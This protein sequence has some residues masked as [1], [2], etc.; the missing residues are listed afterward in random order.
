M[1]ALAPAAEVENLLELTVRH[2]FEAQAGQSYRLGVDISVWFEELQRATGLNISVNTGQ[3]AV[4]Q[5]LFWRLCH[6][7]SMPVV[8]VFVFDGPGR[9][10]VKRG[11]NVRGTPHW[12]TAGA[13]SLIKAFGFQY[14]IAP[15]EAEALLAS[16]NMAGI[17]DAVVTTD[18]DAFVFGAA[19]V[20]QTWK[21]NQ[22]RGMVKIFRTANIQEKVDQHLTN[23]GFLLYAL[24][25]GG[26]YDKGLQNCGAGT[27]LGVVKYGLGT[28]LCDA[29]SAPD[30][31][32]ALVTWRAELC[33]ILRTDPQQH[34]GGR[35]PAAADHIGTAF[36]N[37]QTLEAY[38]N[39]MSSLSDTQEPV[40]VAP[41]L[42]RIGELCERYFEWGGR[43]TILD[44]LA[45]HVWPGIVLRMLLTD[46]INSDTT[47]VSNSTSKFAISRII[48]QRLSNGITE[49]KLVFSTDELAEA[50]LSCLHDDSTAR[51]GQKQEHVNHVGNMNVWI[52]DP[53]YKAWVA[54]NVSSH[55]LIADLDEI[56]EEFHKKT[57]NHSPSES[58]DS[59]FSHD[60]TGSPIPFTATA[61][62]VSDP[63]SDDI[64][65]DLTG[66]NEPQQFIMPRAL[67]VSSSIIDLTGPDSPLLVPEEL[68]GSVID[69]T[70]DSCPPSPLITLPPQSSSF[71]ATP[72][73][74][75]P[76]QL[77]PLKGFVHEV[78]RHS[79]TSGTVLQTA[80]CYLEAIRTKVPELME[81]EKSGMDI[82][83]EVDISHQIGQG[84]LEAEEWRK[85]ALG[86]VMADF[87]HLDAAVD[88]DAMPMV[89]APEQ[90][91]AVHPV[92]VP[93]PTLTTTGLKSHV[94][95]QNLAK[96]LKVPSGPL[97]RHA[98]PALAAPLHSPLLCP[99][100]TF[101][102]SLILA[103]K[104][105][106]DRCYSNKAWAKLSG[107]LPRKIGCCECVLGNARNWR[108]WSARRLPATPA[109]QSDGNLFAPSH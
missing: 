41:N 105:T 79:R 18:S 44:K 100:R 69:L 38:T 5:G 66:S 19:T 10:D 76:P 48:R 107:L 43:D 98:A 60:Y 106:Q 108:L 54:R 56:P 12:M 17:I 84:N 96:K 64:V 55:F 4:L 42:P 24:L 68:V 52:P 97:P 27:A 3:N 45:K 90:Q 37:Q 103:S 25:A 32:M 16:M 35:R 85:L 8:S 1:L 29:M 57:R 65:I 36:P 46:I 74:F 72:E 20:I 67:S 71:P 39:S 15:G 2:G 99:R 13:Q 81:R 63:S 21:L 31:G 102:A 89:K 94:A 49:N 82:Q 73:H 9:P 7:L 59:I 53:I 88:R 30:S 86:S 6:L 80:L 40:L 22:D 61:I 50:S 77:V 26:D 23:G 33:N 104:F 34:I 75:Q 28:S 70:D 11:K 58:S 62:N 51:T 91:V 14:I 92:S 87:I 93:T 47:L 78:L 95:Q 109:S 101:L 83:G